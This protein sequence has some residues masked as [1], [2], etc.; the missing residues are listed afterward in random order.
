MIVLH[1][2]GRPI[3]DEYQFADSATAL[4]AIFLRALSI[5]YLR[6]ITIHILAKPRNEAMIE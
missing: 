6:Q 4:I 3:F 5:K 2:A 1:G